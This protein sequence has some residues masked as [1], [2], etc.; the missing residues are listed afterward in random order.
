MKLFSKKEKGIP[1]EM[2]ALV[3]PSAG[4]EPL[5]TFSGEA[6]D[7]IRYLVTRLHQREGLPKRISMVAALRKEGVSYLSQALAATMAYDLAAKV[8]LVDL[9]YWWSNKLFSLGEHYQSWANVISGDVELKQA[10]IPT[11]WSNFS[12]LPA[13]NIARLQ[14][15]MV[16][17]SQSLRELIEELSSEFDHL[18][19]DVPAILATTDSVALAS[20]GT[21]CCL[22]IRQG[23]TQSGDVSQAL[24]RIEHLP[25]MGVVLNRVRL[26]TPSQLVKMVSF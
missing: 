22:V 25:M 4:D 10:L 9:N 3:V 6:V 17:N 11:G 18:I 14:H 12:I 13:G 5:E 24:D 8:C 2:P 26:E 23:I 7:S 16:A 1:E 20:L 19:L 21:A 15:S